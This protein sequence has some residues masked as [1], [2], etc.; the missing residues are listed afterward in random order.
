MPNEDIPRGKVAKII[1]RISNLCD[2]SQQED[3]EFYLNDIVYDLDNFRAR[4]G[5]HH[6]R[7]YLHYADDQQK[8]LLTTFLELPTGHLLPA[9]AKHLLIGYMTVLFAEQLQ[10]GIRDRKIIKMRAALDLVLAI[11]E[12]IDIFI[13]L[14]LV[15]RQL[16]NLRHR[17]SSRFN[18]ICVLIEE[19]C[20]E[21]RWFINTREEYQQKF[22]I[23]K[24]TL[25]ALADLFPGNY[26]AQLIQNFLHN[27]D[28]EINHLP[29]VLL[30][31]LHYLNIAPDILSRIE[32]QMTTLD[33]ALI[34]FAQLPLPPIYSATPSMG[35][36]QENHQNVEGP[37]NIVVIENFPFDRNHFMIGRGSKAA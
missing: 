24:R 20:E 28:N 36:V 30:D 4:P 26:Y 21:S 8:D 27:S 3:V 31:A 32:G 34:H 15:E 2:V 17:F 10:Y 1:N 13:A 9:G 23:F 14:Y 5:A 29:I 11:E 7:S 19:Q 35:V 18:E 6:Y 25:K 16:P 22:S 33:E 37:M 12:G